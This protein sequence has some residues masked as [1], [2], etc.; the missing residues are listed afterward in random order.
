MPANKDI[1]S[2]PVYS[3]TGNNATQLCAH[4]ATEPPRSVEILGLQPMPA[5]RHSGQNKWTRNIL[6]LIR[7]GQIEADTCLENCYIRTTKPKTCRKWRSTPRD[8]RTL[9]IMNYRA[10]LVGA[11]LEIKGAAAGG[12]RVTCKM[13]LSARK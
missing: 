12:T 10:S 4:R 1:D 7:L 13:P 2:I 9:R 5:P 8:S 6:Y 11:T 3:T